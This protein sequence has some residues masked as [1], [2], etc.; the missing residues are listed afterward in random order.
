MDV[1]NSITQY[2]PLG[3]N[4]GSTGY[5]PHLHL[6]TLPL[7]KDV[8]SDT[9]NKNPLE[10]INYEASGYNIEVR[11]ELNPGGITLKYPGTQ[12]TSLRI[13]PKLL[14]EAENDNRYNQIYDVNKV[15]VLIQKPGESTYEKIKGLKSDLE[16]DLGGKL[17]TTL[18]TIRKQLKEERITMAHGLNMVLIHLLIIPERHRRMMIFT[19]RIL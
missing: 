3:P 14:N 5:T 7:S 8:I 16:I 2:D 9:H 11:S 10:F 6:C 4:G 12:I 13:R 17:G 18:K 15:K 19:F 1:S